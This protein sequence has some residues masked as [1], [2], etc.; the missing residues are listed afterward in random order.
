MHV[1]IFCV[2]VYARMY[3]TV[4]NIDTVPWPSLMYAGPKEVR[5]LR[6]SIAR[7]TYEL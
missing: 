4:C 6:K 1:D 7:S 2:Y 3:Q 5:M